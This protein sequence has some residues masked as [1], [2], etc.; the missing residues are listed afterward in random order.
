MPNAH[1][2]YAAPS[3][4][5]PAYAPAQPGASLSMEIARSDPRNPEHQAMLLARIRELRASMPADAHSDLAANL[6]MASTL[7]QYLIRMGRIRP[8]DVLQIVSRL[9]GDVEKMS[10]GRPPPVV[11]GAK[12]GSEGN[13]RLIGTVDESRGRLLGEIMIQLGFCTRQK[14]NQALKIHKA[15]GVRLGE[16]LVSA[17]AATWEQVKR[18]I[19][20]QNQIKKG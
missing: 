11:L 17:G 5:Q 2:G 19:S 13:L 6:D 20:V 1:P 4:G 18:A 15:T 9:I 7:T 8:E 16:A 3:H 12:E 10:R 14:V